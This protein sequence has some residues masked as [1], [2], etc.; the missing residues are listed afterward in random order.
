MSLTDTAPADR[1]SILL[2]IPDSE[3]RRR[4]AELLRSEGHLVAEAANAGE[5]KKHIDQLGDRRWDAIVCAGLLSEQDDPDLA[6]R[7]RQPTLARALVLLP[8]GGLLST[9]SR[10]QRVGASA[11]LAD[12][13]GLR[14]LLAHGGPGPG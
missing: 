3:E 13:A 1:R 12:L 2:G 14:R 4:V 5:M 8:A 10:A 9:A 6:A 7:L 11:V